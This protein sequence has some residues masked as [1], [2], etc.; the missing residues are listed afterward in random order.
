MK[1]NGRI[2]LGGASSWP[3]FSHV[4]SAGSYFVDNDREPQK[5]NKTNTP[6][7]AGPLTEEQYIHVMLRWTARIYGVVRFFSMI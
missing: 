5:V 7:G 6:V 2:I 4:E 3:L 1:V